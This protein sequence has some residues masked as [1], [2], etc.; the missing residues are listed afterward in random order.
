MRTP[1]ANCHLLKREDMRT[2]SLSKYA[3]GVATRREANK[4]LPVA[5]QAND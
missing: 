4:T 5:S 2:A 1:E 3:N